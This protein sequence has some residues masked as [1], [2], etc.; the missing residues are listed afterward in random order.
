VTGY[1]YARSSSCTG[2]TTSTSTA[3]ARRPATSCIVQPGLALATMV[4]PV[5]AT[6]SAL[7]RRSS[8]DISGCV[9]L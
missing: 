1:P 3:S 6:A 7:L 4:A 2:W 5:A 9:T 8:P